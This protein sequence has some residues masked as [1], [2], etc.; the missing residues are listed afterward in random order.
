M[1]SYDSFYDII[2]LFTQCFYIPRWDLNISIYIT[3]FV[4]YTNFHWV[5]GLQSPQNNN[6]ITINKTFSL[7]NFRCHGVTPRFWVKKCYVLYLLERCYVRSMRSYDSFYDIIHLFT[8]CFYI[9]VTI[10]FLMSYAGQN[11]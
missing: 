1:R 6:N 2:H 10:F 11:W 5:L 7:E 9:F 4:C 3:D 8:Q